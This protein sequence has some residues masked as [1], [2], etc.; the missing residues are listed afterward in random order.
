MKKLFNPLIAMVLLTFAITSC[1]NGNADF[2]IVD[3]AP[4]ISISDP[5]SIVQG[6]A[7]S[8]S[9][10]F[11]DGSEDLAQSTLASASYDLTNATASVSS[12]TFSVSGRTA[13]GTV[14]IAGGLAEGSYTL[15]VT[16]VDTNGNSGTETFSFDVTSDFSVGIIGSA[17][18]TGWDSDTDLTFVTGTQ[19][20]LTIDLT[21]G[22]AKFRTND[23]WGTNWGDS[24]FPMGTGVQD[25]DN[26]PI[27]AA[28]TYLVTFDTSTGAYSFT[29]Q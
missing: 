6:A 28:G 12:G 21:A 23:D 26:I 29:A 11:T 18:P 3:V 8:I 16:A 9:V 17:T 5:G 19:Y 10:D 4:V 7:V 22:E 2:N 15:S 20:E 25:G 1:D 24:A 27:G 14:S 13:T